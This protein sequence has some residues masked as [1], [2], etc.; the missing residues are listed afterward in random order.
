LHDEDYTDDF[1]IEPFE[2]YQKLIQINVHKSTGPDVIPNWLLKDMAPFIAEP[3]CAIFNASVRQGHVPDLWKR[4]NVAPV[5]KITVPNNI[6]SNLRPIS[7]TPALAKILES[8]FG[9]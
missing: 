5:P 2:V 8:F 1:I 4:A 6:H 7:L 9:Q 3:I